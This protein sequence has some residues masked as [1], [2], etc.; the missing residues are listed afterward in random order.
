MNAEIK[1]T[2]I[3]D[4]TNEMTTSADLGTAPDTAIF[5]DTKKKKKK[6]RT[7]KEIAMARETD[8]FIKEQK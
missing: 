8:T 5:K 3:H 4:I 7:F 2:N 6:L 1:V